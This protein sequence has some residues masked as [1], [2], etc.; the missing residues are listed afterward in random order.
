M[1]RKILLSAYFACNIGDDLFLK[2]LFDRYQNIEWHLLTAN[3]NY[4]KIFK[5]YKNVK[6]IY[7]YRELPFGNKRKNLFYTINEWFLG[8]GN[9]LAYVNIGG[10]IFMQSPAW[11]SKFDEREYLINKFKSMGKKTFI[12]GANFGPFK[13]EEFSNKYKELLSR[14]DDVC[15]RDNHS[16]NLFKEMKNIRIAPDIVFSLD[17]KPS[18]KKEKSIGFSIINLENRDSLKEYYHDYNEK[19]I[20]IIIKY[21]NDGYKIKLFSFCENEGDLKVIKYIVEHFPKGER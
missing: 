17:Y 7:S 8:F 4:N 6:I 21:L 20:E 18:E 13:D 15:F 14:L 9:Y 16:Y 12:I 1:K 11:R 5:D 3:R 10:S 19:I 2:I